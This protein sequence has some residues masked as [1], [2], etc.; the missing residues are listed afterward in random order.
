[1]TT[2]ERSFPARS[3]R[4]ELLD[5]LRGIAIIAVM[6]LHFSERGRESGDHLVHD[7]LWP[8]LQHGYLGVQLFFVISGYCI[9]AALYGAMKK[10]TPFRYFMTRRLR[11]IFPPYWFS[12]IL[13]VLL[14]WMTILILKTPSAVVFPL[15]NFDWFCNVFLIQGPLHAK[16]A[17]LVYWSLSIEIQFYLVMAVGLLLRKQ[18]EAW[19]LFVTAAFML[20]EHTAPWPLWGTIIVYWP[21]FVCGIAAYYWLTQR[22]EWKWT[23]ALLIL[24]V[25]L[26]LGLHI[27]QYEA[28]IQPDGRFIRPLKILFCLVCMILMLALKRFDRSISG[29]RPMGPL[30]WFGVISYSLYLTHVPVGTRLF[31]LTD[32]LI[33]LDGLKWLFCGVMAMV[34][35]T[36]FGWFFFRWFEKPW[37][38][39]PP[40]ETPQAEVQ[41]IRQPMHEGIAT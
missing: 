5:P 7:R 41:V 16:D 23:P 34:V 39:S 14:G 36:S 25:A 17:N 29:S 37:L 9:A 35:C 40:P 28:F 24:L 33:G 1:M 32:R 3:A 8:I 31:N 11:R 12:I 27:L 38:N 18:T 10:E 15:S 20:F 2:T 30:T 26:N 22:M 4:Y 19:L 13:V 6:L 21:E